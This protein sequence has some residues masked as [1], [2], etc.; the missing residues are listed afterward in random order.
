M[1]VLVTSMILILTAAWMVDAVLR[2]EDVK[3]WRLASR[4]VRAQLATLDAGEASVAINRHFLSFFEAVY[5]SSFWSLKRFIRSCISSLFALVVI[6]LALGWQDTVF[7]ER[8]LFDFK[9]YLGP[10]TGVILGNLLG[11]YLSLQETRWVMARSQ[12]SGLAGL[13]FWFTLDI[14][15]TTMIFVSF[16]LLV[17]FVWGAPVRDVV[18]DLPDFLLGKAEGLPFWLSTFF[19]SAIWFGYVAVA[20]GI[21]FVQRLSPGMSIVLRT[22]GESDTPARATAG[23]AC[24][25]LVIGYG[26]SSLVTALWSLAR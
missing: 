2:E 15:A 7:G 11:D 8:D 16:L 22:I 3:R 12:G 4:E 19:T 10:V 1:V 23:F 21:R 18:V 17:V 5:G 26:G 9:A 14:V 25:A 6:V 20:L 13:L 24:A